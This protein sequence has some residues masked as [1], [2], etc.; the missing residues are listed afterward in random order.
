[1]MKRSKCVLA[2]GLFVA[3]TCLMYTTQVCA[4]DVTKIGAYLPLTGWAANYGEDAKRGIDLAVEEVNSKGGIR[5]KTVEVIYEDSG[6]NPKQS[7]S[8]VQKLINID[9]VPII[10]GG[11]FSHEALAVGPIC[12]SA[13]VPAIATQASHA[14]VTKPGEFTFR[15]APPM[16]MEYLILDYVYKVIGA[17]RYA[18]LVFSTDMGRTSMKMAEEYFPKLGGEI[19][20]IEFFPMGTT[21]FKTHLFKI[22]EAN[23]DVIEIKGGIKETAQIIKQMQELGLDI[24]IIGSNM[25]R[26]PKLWEL[27]G[28]ALKGVAYPTYSPAGAAKARH[29]EFFSRYEAKY[30][31]A[32]K[33]V[34]ATF[35]YEAANLAMYA[36]DKGGDSGPEA[37][38]ALSTMKDF[39]GITGDITFVKG[40]RKAQY[41]VEKI[42]GPGVFEMTDFCT[43]ILGGT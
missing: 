38:K 24:P 29:D 1:M 31:F 16:G 30:G 2:I 19:A 34:T 42:M 8:A 14:D 39:P 35:T 32:P 40:E 27:V 28:E 33:T 23:P 37:Q 10:V 11:L 13:K 9:K 6:G 43:M 26:E 4:G 3:L 12:Q 22:K 36:L 7:V 17:K 15:I 5:G 41:C 25:F 21:D 20:R 18:A